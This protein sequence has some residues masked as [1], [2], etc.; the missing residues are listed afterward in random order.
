[1]IAGGVTDETAA[2]YHADTKARRAALSSS[3]AQTLLAES[4]RHAWAQHPRLNP[5]HVRT[6]DAKF[7]VGNVAHAAILEGIDVV[8]YTDEWTEWRTNDAKAWREDVR[9]RGRIPLLAAQYQAV[10]EMVAAVF[11]QLSQHRADPPLF[12]DGRAEA[13]LRWFDTGVECR[14]LLDWLRTDLRAIDDLKTTSR[15]ANPYAYARNLYQ[16]GGDV[17]AAFYIRG[18]QRAFD[19]ERA[20]VFRWVVVETTPPY[21]LSVITPAPDVLAVANDKIDTA[22]RLWA[23][24]LELE[25]EWPAYPL[26]VVRAELPPWEETRWLEKRE[27]MK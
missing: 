10:G 23:E 20:P 5:D 21:A 19:V 2:E 17:Q 11:T 9:A 4:P 25:T 26:D 1:M 13:A 8:E 7:D 3:I 15:S 22:L 18:V 16:H 6:E 27:A 24:L 12:A 14:G